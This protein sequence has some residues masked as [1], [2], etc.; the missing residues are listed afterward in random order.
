ME[1]ITMQP[2]MTSVVAIKKEGVTRQRISYVN[3]IIRDD[4]FDEKGG[5]YN[6]FPQ[7]FA[8]VLSGSPT[9]SSCITVLKDFIE[10]DSIGNELG[11]LVVNS[12]DETLDE[13]NRQV[14]ND[15]AYLSRFAVLVNYKVEINSAVTKIVG[16]LKG[17]IKPATQKR[18][19]SQ[20]DGLLKNQGLQVTGINLR[21][22]PAEYVRYGE[23][24]FQ[25]EVRHV[26]YN[27]YI[28]TSE[29]TLKTQERK[30]PLFDPDNVLDDFYLYQEM[31]A[32]SKT[33]YEFGQVLFYNKT[34]ELDRIYSKPS[35]V[36]AKDAMLAEAE[37]FLYH[38]RN[39]QNNFLLGGVINAYG[40][41]N[42]PIIERNGEESSWKTVG[43]ELTQQLQDV[44]AGAKNAGAFIVMWNRLAEEKM[45]I[46]PFSGNANDSKFSSVTTQIR[47]TIITAMQV[48]PILAGVQ[49]AGKLGDSQEKEGAIMYM[50]NRVKGLINAKDNALTRLMSKKYGVLTEVRTIKKKEV[51][52]IKEEIKEE[53]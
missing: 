34:S 16:K 20:L 24:D 49:V 39:I 30:Y 12:D 4:F 40:N 27:P 42:Q 36:S 50:N 2:T 31:N 21:H 18:Y 53:I 51:I 44:F 6:D 26:V 37:I 3:G 45:D 10:G 22:L 48:P 32:D 41:P 47:D 38:L 15:L 14:S 9:A 7:L 19:L 43:S 25:G 17:N 35:F 23:P 11:G 5:A 8:S 29:E 52:E 28:G 1:D 46:Q 33:N 13:L